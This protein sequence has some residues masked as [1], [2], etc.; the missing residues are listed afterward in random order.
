[1]TEIVMVREKGHLVPRDPYSH[2]VVMA[3]QPGKDVFVDV[4]QAR[5][6][7]QHKLLFALLHKV[8]ATD[9][10]GRSVD[11]LLRDLKIAAGMAT[12]VVKVHTNPRTGAAIVDPATG[13]PKVTTYLV[14]ESLA[15][16]SMDQAR[17]REVFDRFVGLLC[18]DVL[19]GTG[20]DRLLAEVL[21]TIK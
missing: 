14:L 12:P 20:R 3:L 19:P 4:R 21:E 2:D 9:P 13:A 1:M 18:T 16:Q 6:P 15:F 17:F 7:K 8:A 11:E 10:K 5:N